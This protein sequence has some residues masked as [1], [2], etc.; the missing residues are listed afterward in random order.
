MNV[1]ELKPSTLEE[2]LDECDAR[3]KG[4]VKSIDRVENRLDNIEQV[5]LEIKQAIDNQ[6]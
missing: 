5:L 2:H 1:I 4:L 6:K 3:Y